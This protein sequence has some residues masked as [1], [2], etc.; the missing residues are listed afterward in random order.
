MH[1]CIVTFRD[2]RTISVLVVTKCTANAV[3]QNC[4]V[5]IAQ[6]SEF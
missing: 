2:L 4:K 6:A 1:V 3:A 5:L